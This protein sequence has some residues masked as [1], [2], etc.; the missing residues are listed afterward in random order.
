VC[1]GL[2]FGLPCETREYLFMLIYG[3]ISIARLDR[4]RE[5]ERGPEGPV[6]PFPNESSLEI[7]E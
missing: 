6:D 4:E 1:A 7:K 2:F 3:Q 5:R